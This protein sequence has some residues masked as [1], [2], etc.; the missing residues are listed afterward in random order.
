MDYKE[1]IISA[2]NAENWNEVAKLANEAKL[3]HNEETA[4]GIKK[5]Y[6]NVFKYSPLYWQ[7]K[8]KY[9]N[10]IT[11]LKEIGYDC[12]TE[13][14]IN[15]STLKDF[16]EKYT[17]D[18][19]NNNYC[20]VITDNVGFCAKLSKMNYP[21]QYFTLSYRTS[22]KNKDEKI[23]RFHVSSDTEKYVFTDMNQIRASLRDDRINEIFED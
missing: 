19:I 18:Y 5:G 3:N 9:D 7:Q 10:I 23:I 20:V 11:G 12:Y 16:K 21:I 17:E 15:K 8:N 14:Y 4:F 22:T 2:A 1:L 6:I 13:K